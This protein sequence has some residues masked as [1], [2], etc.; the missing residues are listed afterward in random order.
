MIVSFKARI[1]SEQSCRS[2][3]VKKTNKNYKQRNPH[4]V[5][6]ASGQSLWRQAAKTQVEDATNTQVE[7]Q[8]HLAAF[9]TMSWLSKSLVAP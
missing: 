4:F 1:C 9:E 8:K 3:H 7:K 2:T 6:S 5:A